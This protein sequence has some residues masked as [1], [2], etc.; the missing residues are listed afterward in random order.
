M[1]SNYENNNFSTPNLLQ[2]LNSN[3]TFTNNNKSESIIFNP[4]IEKFRYESTDK[5]PTSNISKQIPE[6]EDKNKELH[7]KQFKFVEGLSKYHKQTVTML[8][9]NIL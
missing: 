4:Q 6:K 1:I 2:T 5:T 8:K 9:G 7:E 3:S